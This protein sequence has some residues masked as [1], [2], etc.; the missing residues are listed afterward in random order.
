MHELDTRV[1][2]LA[3]KDFLDNLV[4]DRRA[5]RVDAIA[6]FWRQACVMI[7]IAGKLDGF[8]TG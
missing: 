2:V 5:K 1:E 6:T 4:L 7:Y 3:A 8:D